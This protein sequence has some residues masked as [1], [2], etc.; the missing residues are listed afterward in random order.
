MCIKKN[1]DGSWHAD[2]PA[3]LT[4]L[5]QV[6]VLAVAVSAIHY[7]AIG[8]I[9]T[10]IGG[11]SIRLESLE[12]EQDRHCD[13]LDDLSTAVNRHAGEHKGNP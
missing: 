5:I 2:W 7:K 9:K 11:H 4:L 6:I 3:V 10:L 13:K 8:E 12:K 1:G